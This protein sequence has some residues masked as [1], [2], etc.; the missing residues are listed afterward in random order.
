MDAVEGPAEGCRWTCI[1]GRW[2]AISKRGGDLADTVATW[3]SDSP[4]GPFTPKEV[5]D[6]PFETD[7]RTTEDDEDKIISYMPR[8]H[9]EIPTDPG[10]MIVSVSAQ[11][12][13]TSTSCSGRP[14]LRRSRCS[15]RCPGP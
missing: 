14:E 15:P 4:T 6:A 10:T 13:R 8:R 7:G 12:L 1:D 9:V 5:L 11:H 3:T 2:S